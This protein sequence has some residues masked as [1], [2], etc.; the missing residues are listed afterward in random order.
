M[1]DR[2]MDKFQEMNTIGKVM[3]CAGA[4]VAIVLVPVLVFLGHHDKAWKWR[5]KPDVTE[6]TIEA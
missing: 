4:A 3:I 6:E 2:V 5:K 1:K